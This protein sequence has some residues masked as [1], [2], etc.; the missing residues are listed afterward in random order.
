[1]TAAEKEAK[2]KEIRNR[3]KAA[4]NAKLKELL[5][6]AR[7]EEGAMSEADGADAFSEIEMSI[8]CLRDQIGDALDGWAEGGFMDDDDPPDPFLQIAGLA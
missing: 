4:L 5:A 7:A 1:M 2:A 6:A 8:G 3:L